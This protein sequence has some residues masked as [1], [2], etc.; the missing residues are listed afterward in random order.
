[1]TAPRATVLLLN[2]N[3]GGRVGAAIAGALAQTVPCDIVVSDDASPDDS[4]ARIQQTLDAD[5]GPH[6]VRA[7]RNPENLGLG[8]HLSARMA[9][10]DT[11]VVVQMAGDDVSYPHRVERLLAAFDAD[12]RVMVAGS[13]Y[14]KVDDDGNDIGPGKARVPDSFDIRHFANAGRFTTL[15]GASM[16][17]RREVFDRIGPLHASVEDNA[18]TMRG[19]LLGRGV[20]LPD[21][22]L[23]Y[24]VGAGNLS[25][26]VFAKGDGSQEA[27]Q[28]RYRRLLRMYRDVADDLDGAIA[29]VGEAGIATDPVV[30][31]AARQVASMYR[32]EADQREAILERPRIEWI[33]PLWQGLIRPGL[34]RKSAERAVKLLL[35]RKWFGATR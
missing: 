13:G 29:R 15:L 31:R 34:R 17:W 25:S 27:F 28:R 33:A 16:A 26:W 12:P 11:D 24:T 19:A 30:L 10:V 18:M 1:M 14:D 21:R 6:R 5:H 9:E 22:L 23:R 3:T 7:V 8:A 35:P 20:Q 4:W 2:Y 32:L